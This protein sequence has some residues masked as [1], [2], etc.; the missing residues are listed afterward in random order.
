MPVLL[1]VLPVVIAFIIIPALVF[2]VPL[3]IL[4]LMLMLLVIALI[5]ISLL[6]GISLLLLVLLALNIVGKQLLSLCFIWYLQMYGLQA[7]LS[8][9]FC[10]MTSLS[11]ASVALNH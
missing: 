3:A 6:A 10:P 11:Q 7:G 9:C 2:L 1:L 8:N 4:V 5:G